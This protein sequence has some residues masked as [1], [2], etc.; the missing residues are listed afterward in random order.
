[1]YPISDLSRE[2]IWINFYNSFNLTKFEYSNWHCTN[3]HT[4]HFQKLWIK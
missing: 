3:V 4:K 2:D 1:M